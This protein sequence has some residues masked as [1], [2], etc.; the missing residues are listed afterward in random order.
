M[1]QDLSLEP[2]IR[3]FVDL[4]STPSSKGWWT[5]KCAVCSDYKKR[6]GFNFDG[7]TTSYHCFNCG[8]TATHDP[9]SY[10]SYTDDMVTVL[11]NFG[12]PEDSYKPINL[13]SLKSKYK[14]GSK[15]EE[16]HVVD[17]DTKIIPVEFPN[18]FKPLNECNDTWSEV[19]TEYLENYRCVDPSSYPFY[20]LDPQPKTKEIERKWRGRIIIPFFRNNNIVYYQ[21]RDLR[22]DSKMRYNNAE[23][24][25]ECILSNYDILFQDYD[26]PLY[27]CEGFFDAHMVNGVA[28]FGNVLKAGQIKIL[29][30]TRREKV[31]V[32]DR[33]RDGQRGALQA[34]EQGWKVSVPDIGSAKDI[35]RAV[36]K[37]GLLYV[38][39]TLKK[40]IKSGYAGEIAVRTLVFDTEK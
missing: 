10:S 20:L 19:A 24:T 9:I 30:K 5:C 33:T 17:P 4:S 18:Y 26:K 14:N 34:L 25:S 7:Q 1:N 11:T 31:Y 16:K 23:T 8:H 6:G 36:R 3:Q 29:N 2:L 38:M 13:N 28:T 35:N 39:T 21:G 15:K 40:N 22:P 37:Y 32:P 12:I 27:I